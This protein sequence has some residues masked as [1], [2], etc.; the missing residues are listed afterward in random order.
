[1]V[2][3]EFKRIINDSEI[4]KEDDYRWPEKNRDGKQ[5]LEVRLGKFHISFEVSI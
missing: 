4:L 2:F 1:M 5:E 3:K